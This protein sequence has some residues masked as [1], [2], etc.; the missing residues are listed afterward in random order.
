M[1]L[2]KSTQT[3]CS[4]SLNRAQ[5]AKSSPGAVLPQNKA[6]QPRKKHATST[7]AVVL[8]YRN[9]ILLLRPLLPGALQG[10]AMKN[11]HDQQTLLQVAHATP[12]PTTSAAATHSRDK[13]RTAVSV[14]LPRAAPQSPL[15]RPHYSRSPKN[16]L[17]QLSQECSISASAGS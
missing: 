12:L 2:F 6:R 5:S 1:F 17:M 9:G 16:P 4:S 8:S 14:K 13:H 10:M 3:V 7:H 11:A 15:S